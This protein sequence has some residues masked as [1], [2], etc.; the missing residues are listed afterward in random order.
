M[1]RAPYPTI[2]KVEAMQLGLLEKEERRIGF[3]VVLLWI[4]YVA[5][6]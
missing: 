3:C 4:S 6:S 5:A 2:L 1:N